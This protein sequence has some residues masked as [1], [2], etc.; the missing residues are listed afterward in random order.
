MF[1]RR[2]PT[3]VDSSSSFRITLVIVLSPYQVVEPHVHRDRG[4]R[5]GGYGGFGEAYTTD[6]AGSCH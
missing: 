3:M 5:E 4:A 1:L 6:V 2:P